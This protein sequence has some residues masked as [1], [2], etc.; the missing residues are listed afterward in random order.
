MREANSYA[1]SSGN[2]NISTDANTT[3]ISSL[4]YGYTYNFT[5]KATGNGSS[6]EVTAEVEMLDLDG[7]DEVV[8]SMVALQNPVAGGGTKEYT[9]D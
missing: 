5:N 3:T 9:Q 6:S 8:F 1:I 7:G 2:I 4:L